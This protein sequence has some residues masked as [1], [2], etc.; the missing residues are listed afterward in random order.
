MQFW[1][2]I[3][4]VEQAFRGA[5]SP[6]DAHDMSV[7]TPSVVEEMAA[8]QADL[9]QLASALRFE[10]A[11]LMHLT[12]CF[13][14]A[15]A[16][17]SISLLISAVQRTCLQERSIDAYLTEVGAFPKKSAPRVV[18]VGVGSAED[19][20]TL[21]ASHLHA[22]VAAFGAQHSARRFTPHITIARVRSDAPSA[23]RERLRTII[24]GTPRPAPHSWTISSVGLYASRILAE[25][26]TYDLLA[27]A[28]LG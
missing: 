26:K 1:M 19:S 10:P 3:R 11:T 6:F 20:L 2:H 15:T 16:G 12:L 5:V 13:V 18:W 25:K 22:A 17:S 4:C 28:Q 14:G 21:L 24:R 27:T 23:D 7:E 8:R 9:R